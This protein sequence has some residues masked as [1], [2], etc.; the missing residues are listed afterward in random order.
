ML[1]KRLIARPEVCAHSVIVSVS[2]AWTASVAVPWRFSLEAP[3][4]GHYRSCVASV[5]RL[6]GQS[7]T[8][9]PSENDNVPD[10]VAGAGVPLVAGGQ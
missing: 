9:T 3:R 6:G 5:R 4:H 7:V 2:G 8:C 10:S 1:R